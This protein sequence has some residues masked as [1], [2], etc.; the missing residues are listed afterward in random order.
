MLLSLEN[1]Y[2]NDV[3]L[4]RKHTEAEI[5]P[6]HVCHGLSLCFPFITNEC[7]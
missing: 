2:D 6:S 5:S 4:L 7:Y 3:L 1:R